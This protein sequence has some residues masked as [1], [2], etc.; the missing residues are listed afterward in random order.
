MGIKKV[1]LITPG[2]PSVNP[3]IVK[4]ADALCEAG[5]SV[6]VLF[7]F[8]IQ[9]AEAA[10]RELLRHVKWEYKMVGG[11]P[12][13][14]RMLYYFTKIRFKIF[15][16]FN[17]WTNNLFY[18]AERAQARCYDELLTAAKSIKAHW[19]IGHNLG[20]LAVAVKAATYYNA[21]SGFDFEDYHR[22]E[23]L[24]IPRYEEKR[25][26]YLEEKYISKL[27]YISTSSPLITDTI[28]QNFPFFKRSL[29]TLLNCFPLSQQPLFRNKSEND[30]TLQ[31]FWFSQ[32]V[33]NNRG[34]ETL[35]E[36]LNRLNDASIHLTLAG[37]T[38]N[39]MLSYI[40]EHGGSIQKN[41][42]FA[43]IIQPQSLP[44]FAA[45]Y[46]VGMAIEL[47]VPKNRDLCLTNK[48]FI[49]LLA[50]NAIILSKTNMQRLFNNSYKVGE[51][52]DAN[53]AV[54]LA[55]KIRFY[56]NRDKLNAQR[57]H[58]YELAKLVFNWENET[59]K[60]LKVIA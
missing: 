33:G 16:T 27:N 28:E 46:D 20:A 42:H 31:L 36:A 12:S 55:E 19:F 15:K 43:G 10:D 41:I 22:K 53:D 48:I 51:A 2:Q 50:G 18:S 52:F 23:N 5:Y 1:V 49:Y 3:R 60:L 21:A 7:C 38:S 45:K 14:N 59:K 56:K 35:I 17:K 6:T 32:T 26:L 25:I 29:I 54:E 13:K 37:R 4:E 34:L 40:E 57:L 39:G 47:I 24:N 58:N 8:W 44:V 11:S 9:W 30:N